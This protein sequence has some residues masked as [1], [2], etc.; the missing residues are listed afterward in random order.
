[1]KKAI[2]II[3]VFMFCGLASAQFMRRQKVEP[4]P[5]GFK[6]ASTNTFISQ[7]PAVNPQTHQALF[8]V[9]APYANS[10]QLQLGGNHEM[11]KDDKG[12]WWI[13]T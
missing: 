2:L 1:M 11:K 9:A 8:R 13:T 10:V 7:Y 6:P 4:L 3:S 5:E 12:I